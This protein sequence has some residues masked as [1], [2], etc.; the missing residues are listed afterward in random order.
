MQ[1]VSISSIS[2]VISIDTKTTPKFSANNIINTSEFSL[3]PIKKHT[4]LNFTPYI[5]NYEY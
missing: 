3:S 4:N 5:K 1:I 2:N